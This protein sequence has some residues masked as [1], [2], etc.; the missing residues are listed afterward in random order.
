METVHEPRFYLQIYHTMHDIFFLW[1][2]FGCCCFLW[3]VDILVDV[4]KAEVG[5]NDNLISSFSF[6]DKWHK[7]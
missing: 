4:V 7:D 3:M 1:F 6:I 5:R 2:V